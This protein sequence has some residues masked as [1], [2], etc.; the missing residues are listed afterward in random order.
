L[1]SPPVKVFLSLQSSILQTVYIL[2]NT[3]PLPP[4]A[5]G[6]YLPMLGMESSMENRKEEIIEGKS[7]IKSRKGKINMLN[8]CKREAN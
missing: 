4:G 7:E 3:P 5:G 8:I 1:F 2:Q 6:D